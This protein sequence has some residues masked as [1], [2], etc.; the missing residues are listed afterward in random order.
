[1]FKVPLDGLRQSEHLVKTYGLPGPD[2]ALEEC[3][4]KKI[5]ISLESVKADELRGFL[6]LLLPV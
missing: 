4:S 6:K 1:M 3:D 2:V 5:I